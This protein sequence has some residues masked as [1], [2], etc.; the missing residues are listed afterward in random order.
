MKAIKALTLSLGELNKSIITNY[1]LGLMVHKIYQRKEFR[2]EQI[3][4]QKELAEYRD[5]YKY[6]KK[7]LSDGVLDQYSSLPSNA[8]T[9]LGSS[10]LDAE[11][12]VCAVD[13]FAYISH[14]S[15]MTY[16]GVTDRIPSKLFISTPGKK[17]WKV[18]ALKKM[19]KD[20]KE[21]YELYLKNGLP[22]LT[23]IHMLKLGRTEIYNFSSKYLGGYINVRDKNIRV[24]TIGR[25]FLDML[26]NPSM[27]GGINHVL[28]V[29]DEYAE[30]YLKLIVNEIETNGIGIDKVRAGYIISERLGISN[31][32]VESWIKFAQRG[33]SR[34]LDATGE[35]IPVWSEKWCISLNVF[36]KLK[37]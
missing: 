2:G 15:A 14:L 4:L 31:D 30:R 6:R 25:T 8:F 32:I 24:A 34:K 7:L 36:E 1:E 35:Y 10:R 18:Y 9:L 21:D 20:L 3:S 27:C 23:K 12:V 13:P 28:E 16:H 29:F 17:D 5:F 22:L 26:K 33:G 19:E 37:Q 11:E